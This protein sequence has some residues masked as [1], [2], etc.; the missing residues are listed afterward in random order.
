[1]SLKLEPNVAKFYPGDATYLIF[2]GRAFGQDTD[3]CEWQ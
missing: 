2:F 1:M 3:T